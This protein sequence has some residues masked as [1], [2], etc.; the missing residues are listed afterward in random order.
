MYLF[1]SAQML[2]K[3]KKNPS[4][5]RSRTSTLLKF[6]IAT[7]QHTVL[8]QKVSF[9]HFFFYLQSRGSPKKPYNPVLGEYFRCYWDTPN[10]KR[11]A[12]NES[13]AVSKNEGI[14][15]EKIIVFSFLLSFRD[16]LRVGLFLM[17][18]M[19]LWH[20]LQSKFLITLQVR[21]SPLPHPTAAL[22]C[23]CGILYGRNQ[24]QECANVFLLMQYY[25]DVIG[26]TK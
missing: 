4:C 16:F 12:P 5:A 10:S 1:L 21:R 26:W 17:L 11:M 8:V 18:D 14:Q 9:S 15:E 22:H 23:I 24:K 20:I 19:I 6:V 13:E 3:N 25:R 2:T 7:S